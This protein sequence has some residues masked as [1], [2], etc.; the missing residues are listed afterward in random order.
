MSSFLSK[1]FSNSHSPTLGDT[2]R[3]VIDQMFAHG[4]KSG[5]ECPIEYA[6]FGEKNGLND[7]RHELLQRGFKEDTTQSTEM[8]V[9]IQKLPLSYDTIGNA[10]AEMKVLAAKHHV[11]FDGWSCAV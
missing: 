8:I 6:F 9:L 11:T 1:I 2:T 5:Q 4:F 10:I 7:L 3:G